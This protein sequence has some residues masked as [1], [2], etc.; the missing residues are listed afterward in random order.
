[1]RQNFCI[2][3]TLLC[4]TV[5]AVLAHADS[6]TVP[7]NRKN[8]VPARLRKCKVCGFQSEQLAQLCAAELSAADFHFGNAPALGA[9]RAADIR[10]GCVNNRGGVRRAYY[11]AKSVIIHSYLGTEVWRVK[12][13]AALH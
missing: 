12:V 10:R 3:F 11:L 9:G 4:H 2:F 5:C 8:H 1:M 13:A 6:V 7:R